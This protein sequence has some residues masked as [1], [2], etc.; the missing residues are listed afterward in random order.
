MANVANVVIIM[1]FAKSVLQCIFM[2]PTYMTEFLKGAP[3]FQYF[4]YPKNFGQRW[5]HCCGRAKKITAFWGSD[6]LGSPTAAA[7]KSSRMWN[8]HRRQGVKK[9]KYIFLASPGALLR[10]TSHD[11][12]QIFYISNFWWQMYRVAQRIDFSLMQMHSSQVY[13]LH[14]ST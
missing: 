14:L 10:I 1:I 7:S 2:Y 12:C 8:H 6:H 4:T 13:P 9:H 5:S 3:T 11:N